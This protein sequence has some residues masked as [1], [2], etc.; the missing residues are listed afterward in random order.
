MKRAASKVFWRP[1]PPTSSWVR[2]FQSLTSSF[3]FCSSFFTSLSWCLILLQADRFSGC[4]G[5]HLC[6]FRHVLCPSQLCPLFDPGEGKQSQ[7]PPVCQRSESHYLL[8]DQLPLG[9]CKCQVMAPPLPSWAQ[10]GQVFVCSKRIWQGGA[11]VLPGL[12]AGAV[13][14]ALCV[15]W[16]LERHRIRSSKLGKAQLNNC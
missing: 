4:C 3:C 7:A 5:C 14:R 1:L 9:H 12:L 13:L 10:H 11:L 6:D 15:C 2:P 16:L 8:A